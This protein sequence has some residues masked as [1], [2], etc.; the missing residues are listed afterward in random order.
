MLKKVS[1]AF[2]SLVFLT[3][4]LPGWAQ[5]SGVKVVPIGES[6]K[7]EAAPG[8][9]RKRR[10]RAT[11][12]VVKPGEIFIIQLSDALSSGLTKP[13]ERVYFRA[14]EDVGPAKYPVIAAG[15]L[16]RG[17]VLSVDNNKKGGKIEI[18]LDTIENVRGED[19]KISGKIEIKGNNAQA[20]AGVGDRFTATLE[21]KV[22]IKR[23]R[24]KKSKGDGVPAVQQ[25]F[26]ELSGK[27]AQVDLKKGKAKGKVKII[28]EGPKGTTS[29]DIDPSSVMLF[30]VGEWELPEPVYANKGKSRQGDRNKN[31]V[32]DWTLFFGAW[33]FV[34]FQPRG[35]NNITVRGKFRDGTF[36]D[37]VTRVQIDY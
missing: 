19:V 35:K 21:E 10:R 32:S 17:T 13:G 26:V 25:G 27:G 28:L 24:K 34:R 12:S 30:K 8:G 2:L 20:A 36:F 11:K 5:D 15:S 18:Q 7:P 3:A 37:A 9:T 4:S 16:G 23:V 22:T 29:D 6:I 14:S 1:L 31:G 33:D